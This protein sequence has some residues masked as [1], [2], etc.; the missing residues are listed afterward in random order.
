[1]G[2]A[3]H[4]GP[5]ATNSTAKG[6]EEEPVALFNEAPEG[7]GGGDWCGYVMA[8][9]LYM[10]NMMCSSC[11]FF[12]FFFLFSLSELNPYSFFFHFHVGTAV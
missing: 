2:K 10:Q 6:G 7:E 9:H 12:F 4:Y 11:C 8:C 1:M 5:V 3:A